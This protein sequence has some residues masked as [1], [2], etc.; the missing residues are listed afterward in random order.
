[1]SDDRFLVLVVEKK[2][3]R[4]KPSLQ[5]LRLYQGV[6]EVE[7]EVLE[8]SDFPTSSFGNRLFRLRPG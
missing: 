7:V 3:G 6:Q 1:M 2:E 8:E 4:V 5:Y